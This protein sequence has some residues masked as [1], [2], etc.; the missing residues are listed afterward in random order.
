MKILMLL[1]GFICIFLSVES[2]A[3]TMDEYLRQ[4][5]V[6]FGLTT[7]SPL[8][9]NPNTAQVDLGRRLF[10]DVNLSGNKNISCKTCHNPMAGTSDA[11]PL[12][13]T[14]DSKGILRRNS[15]TLFNLSEHSFMFWDGRV[16]YDKN[17]KTL[18]TPE[19]N[20]PKAIADV[21]TSALS[22]QAIFPIVSKEEMKGARGENEIADAKNNIE[23]WSRVVDR[24][25]KEESTNPRHKSYAELFKQSYP[26]TKIEDINIG[27]V[28]E[29]I[30]AF[31][32]EQ[33]QSYG[34]PYFR[35][36]EGD[37]TALTEQEKR[38]FAVFVD[39]GKCIACHQGAELGNNTFFT[40]VA[41][42]QWGAT[43]LKV[44][45]GRAE[46]SNEDFR[47]YFF[48]T[49]SLINV[50]LSAP[51]MHNG[52]FVNLRE[53]INH[54]SNVRNS[55]KNYTIPKNVE[56]SMPVPVGVINGPLELNEIWNSI[57]APFLRQGLN[58]S[59]SEIADLEAF[60]TNALTDPKWLAK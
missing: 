25:I 59:E 23:A 45:Y 16:H 56:L 6:F 22:A 4:K 49:P 55:L 51:Y 20:L 8:P 10:M 31:E 1:S 37:L 46:V 24:L 9:K 47:K 19:K 40:S 60:L 2:S 44:D 5:I 13:R 26:Q 58:L 54:Y 18:T 21:M 42:P 53:V 29:A 57:Q 41:T 28:G 3:A 11:L 48:R 32:K 14:E 43:P 17:S 52:A 7:I 30:G 50:A 34:A 12:S 27:H 39:R 15:Q 33:F 36:I 35:Y 38:G